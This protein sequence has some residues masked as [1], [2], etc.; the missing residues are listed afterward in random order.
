[1]RAAKVESEGV[2]T[3]LRLRRVYPSVA[4]YAGA[5]GV[6][7]EVRHASCAWVGQM[8]R[9]RAGSERADM[10][11]RTQSTLLTHDPNHPYHIQS[12]CTA[13]SVNE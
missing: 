2:E 5:V 4:A 3:K 1:M 6:L 7:R 10:H 13:S 8:E 11:E 12:C 9:S